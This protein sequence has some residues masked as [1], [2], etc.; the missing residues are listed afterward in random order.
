ML[1]STLLSISQSSVEGNTEMSSSAS[2][3]QLIQILDGSNPI[4]IEDIISIME[5]IDAVLL[6]DDGLKWFN[7]LYLMVTRAVQAN[8]P[9]DGFNNPQW[10]TRLDVVFAVLYFTAIKNFIRQSAPTPSSWQAL[11]E[12]R[13]RAGVERIQFALAGMNAHINH[14]LSLALLQADAE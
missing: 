12:A 1:L 10:L 2:D 14:D 7:W 11:F 3:Q 9:A 13:H 4:D 8:P 5:S 6:D